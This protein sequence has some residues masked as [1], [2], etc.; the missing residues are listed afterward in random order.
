MR[1]VHHPIATT[2]DHF[3]LVIQSFHKPTRMP[4]NKVIRDVVEVVL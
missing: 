2:L 4:V 3:E 1:D